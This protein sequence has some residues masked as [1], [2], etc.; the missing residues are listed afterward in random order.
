MY[1]QGT[2]R[3]SKREKEKEAAEAKRREEEE[4]AAKAYAEFLDAFQGE[5]ADRKKGAAAFVKAGQSSSSTYAPSAKKADVSRA[6]DDSS[7]VRLCWCYMQP[8][9]VF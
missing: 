9:S 2:I 3:K 5:G 4:N 7:M 6:F 1:T 8:R